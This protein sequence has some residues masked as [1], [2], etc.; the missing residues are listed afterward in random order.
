MPRGVHLQEKVVLYGEQRPSR[1][2][3][4]LRFVT[5]VS[6]KMSEIE[7]DS[8]LRLWRELSCD[9]SGPSVLA[10]CSQGFR[11]AGRRLYSLCSVVSLMISV[12]LVVGARSTRV[13]DDRATNTIVMNMISPVSMMEEATGT[14]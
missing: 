7:R 5:A 14:C 3:G 10:H 6:D 4:G 9:W 2:K 1:P 12:L 11:V 13:D 8:A